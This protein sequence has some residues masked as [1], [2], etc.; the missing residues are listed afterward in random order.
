SADA[1]QI[2]ALG[3]DGKVT[4][5]PPPPLGIPEPAGA[6][7][8]ISA[9]TYLGCGLR[10]DR[11]FG[12]WGVYFQGQTSAP[13]G[14]FTQIAAEEYSTC[15]LGSDGTIACWGKGA[16]MP[17]PPPGTFTTLGAGWRHACAI[18]ANGSLSCWG[19]N[20][21]GQVTA[22]AHDGF[23]QAVRPGPYTAF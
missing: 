14:T 5:T 18:A 20:T 8:A 15:G 19:D 21:A 23:D 1:Y 11:S 13:A 17:S 12:C 6:F 10:A 16:N 22:P 9:A 3:M 7:A 4:C 2:C